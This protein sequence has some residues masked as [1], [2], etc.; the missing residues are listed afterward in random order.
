VSPYDPLGETEREVAA[1]S[2][3]LVAR[4]HELKIPVT[5]Y[6][7]GNGTHNGPYINRDLKHSFPLI[8]KALG[9]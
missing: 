6:A 9:E 8:L 1:E 4:L 2:A 5:V 3:A 7:Y